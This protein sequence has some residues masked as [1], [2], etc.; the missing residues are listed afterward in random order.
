M[1]ISNVIQQSWQFQLML[2]LLCL[3]KTLHSLKELLCMLPLSRVAKIVFCSLLSLT[4][5]EK[6]GLG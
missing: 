6:I 5:A 1:F 3:C 4:I 2:L